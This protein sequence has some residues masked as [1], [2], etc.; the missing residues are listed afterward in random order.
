MFFRI[1]KKD[2]KR[3]KTMNI[4]LLLFII[5]AS[6]FVAS[7]ISDVI[8]IMNGTDYFLDKAGLGDYVVITRGD[9]SV[10]QILDKSDH[11]SSYRTEECIFGSKDS[12][13]SGDNK[14]EAKNSILIQSI[15]NNGI[16]YFLNDNSEL[17]EISEEGIYVSGG[18]LAANNLKQKDR[19]EISIG[20]TRLSFVIQGEIKDACLGSDMMGNTR[21]I[22]SD[23]AY[24]KFR[25]DETL[26]SY[27]GRIYYID[28]DNVSGLKSD[29]T[30]GNN[31]QFDGSRATIKM[32]Y[33]MEMVVAIIVLVLSIC[34]IIVSFA[35][36]KFVISFSMNEE[37]RE[38]GVMKAIGIKNV[39]IRS[40][41]LIKY[42]AISVIG[43]TIGLF[44]SIPFGNL[45]MDSVSKKMVLGNDGGFTI[46]IAG[47]LL[48]V[49]AIVGF[50]Y[51]CTG[52][53]RKATPVDAIRNGQA[54]ER[55][56][57]KTV[58]RIGKAHTSN[59]LYM[60]VNDIL[61]SPKRFLTII[62]S[63]FLC[64]IFV[65][66][67]V[68]VTDT[69][70]SK[71][72]IG[73]FGKECDAYMTD[74]ETSMKTMCDGGDEL[75]RKIYS[76]IEDK[77]SDAG[78]PGK[79]SAEVCYKYNIISKGQKYTVTFQ[80]NAETQTG[81]Y[82]Y[83]EGTPPQNAYEIAITPAISRMIDA[84]IGDIVAIDFGT[85]KRDCMVVAYFQSMNQLGDIIRLH[86]DAPTSMKYA[87]AILSFQIDFND[88][89]VEKEIRQRIQLMKKIFN[90]DKIYDATEFCKE[91]TGV[92]DTMDSVC[93]LLL[94]I[95]IVVVILVAVLMERSFIFDEKGQIALLKAIG[96]KSRDIL[97]WHIL[98]FMIVAVLS[99]FLAIVL[100]MPVTR[101]WCNP[102]FRMMGAIN[103]KY[104]FNPL[105]VIGV[106]PGAILFVTLL[107]VSITAL[108]TRMIKPN[109]TANIE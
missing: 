17:K 97:R 89:P 42:F 65:L 22:I 7:G 106:Y 64:S 39:K 34:L 99:E 76:D 28:S 83:T 100:V 105:T 104:N 70:K 86:Q 15:K 68:L 96:F 108:Y 14:L 67:V 81:D 31:I 41:Y 48:V 3:K 88:H 62:F 109:D 38:I 90:N 30:N 54:G 19:L 93:Y 8:T 35:V 1:L 37:Y 32:T 72:L 59:P 51:I 12:L 11:V 24:E 102:I 91:N 21:F 56:H 85:E 6:M 101:L 79:V 45:L 2:L 40:L 74:V 69:I 57:K 4:I 36:L 44:L 29:L 5:I 53:V 55:Y 60:A 87:S 66:G 61:S 13:K 58:Y 25:A 20:E 26:T 107:A 10:K 84:R 49:L 71:N 73:C 103:V 33:V 50:S 77:L 23:S 98:R 94:G 92:A 43:G 52:K 75:L 9:D 95:T 16:K 80:K 63:F 78:I 27:Q 18:F 46:N 82:K 47:A